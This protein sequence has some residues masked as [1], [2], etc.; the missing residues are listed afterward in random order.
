MNL[1][2][3]GL[4]KLSL[5]KS[6]NSSHNNNSND[7]NSEVKVA[8]VKREESQDDIKISNNAQ[9]KL[10]DYNSEDNTNFYYNLSS[11]PEPKYAIP[12]PQRLTVPIYDIPTTT[13]QVESIT[14]IIHV[15]VGTKF[16]L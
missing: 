12:L 2:F 1:T 8:K 14:P 13:E 6:N 10:S 5:K 7:N 4:E 9:N 11:K 16:E 3:Y 15:P